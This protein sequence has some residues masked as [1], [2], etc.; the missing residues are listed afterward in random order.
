MNT[1]GFL[2][3]MEND[4]A[5]DKI[6]Y[7]LCDDDLFHLSLTCHF[8]YR[9]LYIRY[10]PIINNAL[11]GEDK[12]KAPIKFKNRFSEIH[13]AKAEKNYEEGCSIE[14]EFLDKAIEYLR[15]ASKECRVALA[16]VS[17]NSEAEAI[18]KIEN[19]KNRIDAKLPGWRLKRNAF[20][21]LGLKF[22]DWVKSSASIEG[23]KRIQSDKIEG[24][25][26]K[27]FP[28]N[29]DLNDWTKE[30]YVVQAFFYQRMGKKR[31]LPTFITSWAK[32]I[33]R[34]I[35]RNWLQSALR[36]LVYCFIR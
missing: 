16:Y 14:D 7:Y 28:Q 9:P 4:N 36:R 10:R 23:L 29:R 11:G 33:H 3:L 12:A 22:E 34:K 31:T 24:L 2:S 35:M 18:N 5:R 1:N 21:Y 13:L 8:F 27:S 20:E 25:P 19:L 6:F 15:L 26:L 17:K 32:S 30:D